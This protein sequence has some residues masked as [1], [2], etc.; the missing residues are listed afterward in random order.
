MS[1]KKAL[2]R[3]SVVVPVYNEVDD[4]GNCL[5]RLVA[6][7]RDIFE[8]I[9]VDNNSSDS[10]LELAQ[11]YAA[12]NKKITVVR[13]KCQGLVP[14]RNRGFRQARSEIVARI[15]AD[16]RV[17]AGWA[18][19]IRRYFA[20]NPSAVAL[21]GQTRY[22]DLPL[23][24]LTSRL[25]SL[26]VDDINSAVTGVDCLYGP[27]MAL[28]AT[29]ARQLASSSCDGNL[30]EDLDLSIHLWEQ[31]FVVGYEPAMLAYVS[32]RRLMSSPASFW[33]Y[34][35]NWPRTYLRHGMRTSALMIY[36]L[37]VFFSLGQAVIYLPLR[38]YDP[39]RAALS[40]RKLLSYGDDRIIP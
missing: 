10:S 7:S 23:D 11:S 39:S 6:Q 22:Y 21:G 40:W 13:E 14:A 29:M 38:A 19:A 15:D 24:N 8:V 12:R 9:V 34:C 32:G 5:E 3:L 27:N 17:E 20:N 28:R 36:P 30:N 31:D 18:K 35:M 2:P 4:L 37:A 16:T 25:S 33:R 26:I 1:S